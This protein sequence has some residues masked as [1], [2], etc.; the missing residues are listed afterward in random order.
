MVGLDLKPPETEMEVYFATLDPCK[1]HQHCLK[2]VKR[3]TPMH[4]HLYYA[5]EVFFENTGKPYAE[6]RVTWEVF[7]KHL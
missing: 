3:G 2:G 6:C 5:G 7:R 4:E 1:T